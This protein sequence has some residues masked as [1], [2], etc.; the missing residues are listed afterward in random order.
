MLCNFDIELIV[1][2][3]GKPIREPEYR[4]SRTHDQFLTQLPVSTE[5][6]TKAMIEQWSATENLEAWPQSLT[7]QLAS[8]KYSADAW[9]QKVP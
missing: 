2:C 3:L 9:T 8:E 6:L 4:Q 5:Q 7:N 1:Q